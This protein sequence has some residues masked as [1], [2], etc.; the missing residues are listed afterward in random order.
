MA[1]LAAHPMDWVLLGGGLWQWGGHRSLTTPR[2]ARGGH[3]DPHP[4][5]GPACRR[6][7]GGAGDPCRALALKTRLRERGGRECGCRY[8]ARPSLAR[9][10]LVE[11]PAGLIRVTVKRP[12]ADGTAGVT[13]PRLSSSSGLQP[14]SRRR[15]L[16]SSKP[17]ACSQG[18]LHGGGRLFQLRLRPHRSGQ[19]CRRRRRPVGMPEP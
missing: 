7:G 17:T 10:R 2:G 1:S 16:T 8:L 5:P 19:R 9:T 12:W 3:S 18:A 6:A 4:L 15:V 13:S 14:R 11:T